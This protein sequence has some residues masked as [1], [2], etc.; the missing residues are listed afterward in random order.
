M[1]QG[2]SAYEIVAIRNETTIDGRRSPQG[3]K[4][5]EY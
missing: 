3:I 4:K 2:L 5:L 1:G